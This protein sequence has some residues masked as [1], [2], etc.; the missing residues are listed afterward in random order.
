M[1]WLV[2]SLQLFTGTATWKSDLS[3]YTENRKDSLVN[4]KDS[5][6]VW[7]REWSPLTFKAMV[8]N[9]TDSR[10]SGRRFKCAEPW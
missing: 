7:E 2:S 6:G 3:V 9:P 1:T 8:E 5:M 4:G 10:F